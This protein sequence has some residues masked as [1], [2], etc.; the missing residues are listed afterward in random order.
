MAA[1]IAHLIDVDE[2]TIKRTE[3][4]MARVGCE[5]V[6]SI[7]KELMI[8]VGKQQRKLILTIIDRIILPPP[9][10]IHTTKVT[11]EMPEPTAADGSPVDKGKAT[12]KGE[13]AIPPMG[14]PFRQ[15][16]LIGD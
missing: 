7:P 2:A 10:P 13:E 14:E 8:V 9:G 12:S 5:S 6:E 16:G 3:L 1:N 15:P 4:A 11:F